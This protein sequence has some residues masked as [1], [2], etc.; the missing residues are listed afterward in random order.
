[1]LERIDLLVLDDGRLES[2]ITD[3]RHDL[4]KVVD[5][6]DYRANPC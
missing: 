4:L 1:V 5:D 2:H 6:R 3:Q